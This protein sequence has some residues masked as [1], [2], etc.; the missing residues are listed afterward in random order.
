MKVNKSMFD[1]SEDILNIFDAKRL[2]S[3]EIDETEKTF[4]T[5]KDTKDSKWNNLEK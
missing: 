5:D 2:K 1:L 4:K 3:K